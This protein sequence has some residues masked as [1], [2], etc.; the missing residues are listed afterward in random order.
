MNRDA[1]NIPDNERAEIVGG[2][3]DSASTMNEAHWWMRQ[4]DSLSALRFYTLL[5]VIVTLPAMIWRQQTGDIGLYFSPSTPPGQLLYV[6]SKLAGM[7]A[8]L[9]IA[10][11]II[12]SLAGRLKLIP[13][14]RMRLSHPLLGSLVVL[15]GV[16]HAL[17][18]FTAVSLRQGDPAW[19]LLFPGFRDFYHTHLTLGVFGLWI[20]IAV[21]IS[22]VVRFIN[23][24]SAARMLHRGYWASITLVY[25]HALAIGT[26]SQSRSGLALYSILGGVVL[27]LLVAWL[28]RRN[29]RVAVA[30]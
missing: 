10:L 28:I 18:F 29:S 8:L 23:G 27:M 3:S 11:Q 20:L 19:G 9:F 14:H 22:G 7:Y 30:S 25:I 13:L 1:N 4:K 12:V 2:I 6:L 24:S 16:A 5:L 15:L 26:E 17:L 21:M